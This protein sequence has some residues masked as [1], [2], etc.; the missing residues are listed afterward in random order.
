MATPKDFGFNED[1][2][3]LKDSYARFL[4]EQATIEKLRP[5]LEGTEDPYHGQPRVPFFDRDNWD[6]TVALGMHA[7]A[8]PED[9]GG[10]GM[11]LVAATA[12]AEEIGRALPLLP[13]FHLANDPPDTAQVFVDNHSTRLFHESRSL[14]LLSPK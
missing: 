2:N 14:P 4:S 3:M 7:V 10:I 5:S 13:I 11:G 6:Q 1:I 9:Q 8:I 12:L